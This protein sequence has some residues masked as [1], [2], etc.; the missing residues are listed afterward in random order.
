[1]IQAFG[2][3]ILDKE[4]KVSE[5]QNFADTLVIEAD[6]IEANPKMKASAK[7]TMEN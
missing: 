3:D 1:L 6:I 5:L 2:Q 4:Y 7:N